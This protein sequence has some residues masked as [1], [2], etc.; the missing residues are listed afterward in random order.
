[1]SGRAPFCF[2]LNTNAPKSPE[3]PARPARTARI[4]IFMKP[5]AALRRERC[6]VLYINKAKCAIR[7]LGDCARKA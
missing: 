5:P 3:S 1:M 6:G 2:I 4:E 7:T